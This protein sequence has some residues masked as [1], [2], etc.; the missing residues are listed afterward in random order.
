MRHHGA[1]LLKLNRN[2]ALVEQLKRD[3]TQADLTPPQRAMLDYAVKLTLTPA[4]MLEQ[5]VEALRQHNFSDRAILDINQIA[6]Y[7]AYVNRLA[8]GLGVELEDFWKEKK[9]RGRGDKETRR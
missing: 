7:F 4:E 6:G 9:T 2:P 1:G 5:D 8:D 3:Y